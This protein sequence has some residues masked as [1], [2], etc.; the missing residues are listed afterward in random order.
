MELEKNVLGYEAQNGNPKHVYLTKLG[1]FIVLYL[2]A[3]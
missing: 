3:N 1:K 2:N